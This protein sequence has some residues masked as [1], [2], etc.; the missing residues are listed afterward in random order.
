MVIN[1]TFL[2]PATVL[3]QMSEEKVTGFSGVPSTYAFLLH[4]SP[5]ASYRDQLPHLRYCSQ[6]G[7]H[8]SKAI[9]V[10]LRNVLPEHTKIFIMYGATEASA[11]LTYLDPRF[12]E[13]KMD[14]VGKPVLDT[15]IQLL[16]TMANRFRQASKVNLWP[17][18]RALCV[19]TGTT[20]KLHRRFSMRWVTT[21]EIS[22]TSTKTDLSI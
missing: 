11:R 8:M 14:S 19:A 13:A 10:A 18:V 20:L 9:K 2:Y 6:A 7:G 5:L 1:N 21:Q 22:D 4:R 12:Y 15:T 16:M 3:K 17:A